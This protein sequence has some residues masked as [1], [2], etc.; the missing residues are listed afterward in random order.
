MSN[1]PNHVT[2]RVEKVLSQL[3]SGELVLDM[4]RLDNVIN[5]EILDSLD[6]VRAFFA[7]D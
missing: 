1:M 5:L 7:T 6:K 2:F 4:E 3:S